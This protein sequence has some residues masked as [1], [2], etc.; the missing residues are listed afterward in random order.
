MGA[1]AL[2][3]RSHDLIAVVPNARLHMPDAALINNHRVRMQ[4]EAKLAEVAAPGAMECTLNADNETTDTVG[5]EREHEGGFG[6]VKCICPASVNADAMDSMFH[7][8]LSGLV[9]ATT[10]RPLS[11]DLT[12]PAAA[13]HVLAGRSD[14]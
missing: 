3:T 13:S 2:C 7:S 9:R 12:F 11:T 1:C 10:R 8:P 6:S 14:L 5:A 4:A